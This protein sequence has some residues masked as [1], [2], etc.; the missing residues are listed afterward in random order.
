MNLCLSAIPAGPSAEEI[1]V[2]FTD[3]CGNINVVKSG[4]PEG[5]DCEWSVT[6]SY[7]ITDDCGNAYGQPVTVTYSGGDTEAPVISGTID[8]IR[9][10][11][12]DVPVAAETVADLTVLGLMIEDN[13]TASDDLVVDYI[14]VSA[15]SCPQIITRTYTITDVCGNDSDPVTQEILILN[16]IN[17]D[18]A[19]ATIQAV[20]TSNQATVE[21][22]ALVSGLDG[23]NIN[24][25]CITFTLTRLVGEEIVET[26]EVDGVSIIDF[27]GNKRITATQTFTLPT[28]ETYRIYNIVVSVSSEGDCFFADADENPATGVLTVYRSNGDMVTGGGYIIP[29][30]SGGTH[31]ATA[32]EKANFG[33]NV[34][35]KPTGIQGELNYKFEFDNREYQVKATSFNTLGVVT[36]LSEGYKKAEFTAVATL[37]ASKKGQ[38]PA[39]NTPGLTLRVTLTDRGE[40]GIYD[41]IGFTLWNGDILVHSSWWMGYY[42]K[43]LPIGGGNL[44][45]HKSLIQNSDVKPLEITDDET[46]AATPLTVYPN[47]T[48]DKAFFDFVPASDNKARLDIFTIDGVH[49]ETLFDGDVAAGKSYQ[50]EYRPALRNNAVLI[51]R[52]IMDGKVQSGKLVTQQ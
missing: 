19:G 35:S 3:N 5:T 40:P 7:I 48:N 10:V 12:S 11:L 16:E 21:L 24:P 34:K 6:Y 2:L 36:Y 28:T 20:N 39:V 25:D 47:P 27:E 42:T 46:L 1:A 9:V 15:G 14:E 38:L 17:I 32:G 37:S 23:C 8:P 52:L 50:I 44:V 31:P 29:H 45:V 13:C 4:D 33:F 30:T 41:E 49:V 18:Y 22:L 43:E 26:I 51:Y